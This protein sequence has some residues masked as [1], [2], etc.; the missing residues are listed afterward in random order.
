MV[1]TGKEVPLGGKEAS[2]VAHA[3]VRRGCARKCAV[4]V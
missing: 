2:G 4:A 1:H 3:K